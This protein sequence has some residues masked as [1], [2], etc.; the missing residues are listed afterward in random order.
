MTRVYLIL[1]CPACG[2]MEG[3]PPTDC[4]YCES[5]G[6]LVETPMVPVPADNVALERED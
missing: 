6:Q 2:A 3:D 4:A 1:T 5:G